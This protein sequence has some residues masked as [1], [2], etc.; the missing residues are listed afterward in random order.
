MQGVGVFCS[1]RPDSVWCHW[2]QVELYESVWKQHVIQFRRLFTQSIKQHLATVPVCHRKPYLSKMLV[3]SLIINPGPWNWKRW[4]DPRTEF[5]TWF[6]GHN[7]AIAF[8]KD[9]IFEK[10]SQKLIHM[11][12]ELRS[13]PDNL[14]WKQQFIQIKFGLISS[15]QS[16]LNWCYV[17]VCSVL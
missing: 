15:T 4:W 16:K 14:P 1:V 12:C 8:T 17:L 11:H 5:E 7:E 13:Y 3:P 10:S 9:I 6:G 2:P